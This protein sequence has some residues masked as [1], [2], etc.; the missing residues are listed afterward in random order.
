MWD[1]WTGDNSQ[2]PNFCE[3]R[4]LRIVLRLRNFMWYPWAE[5][6]SQTRNF[7]WDPWAGDSSQ[8]P[9]FMWDPWAWDSSQTPNFMWDPWAGDSSRTLNHNIILHCIDLN[10]RF[11]FMPSIFKV[12]YYS[13]VAFFY[14]HYMIW[15]KRPSSGVQFVVVKESVAHCKT[16]LF[17]LCSCLSL[18]MVTWVN[19][20]FRFWCPWRHL[21][22]LR[23]FF[24]I[25]WLWLSLMFFFFV[26]GGPPLRSTR[27][28]QW[29]QN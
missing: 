23:F 20:R 25:F 15:P 19:H 1:L 11:A 7:M 13:L 29:H 8:T 17:L 12:S 28:T 21:F 22:F 2:T 26:C 5:D 10:L 4:G 24:F 16:V 3:I 18:L 14:W 6:S 9:N 27:E